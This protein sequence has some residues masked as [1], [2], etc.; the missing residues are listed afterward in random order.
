M[1]LP[2]FSLYIKAANFFPVYAPGVVNWIRK[3]A[4]G[5]TMQFSDADKKMIVEGL[6]KLLKDIEK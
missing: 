3:S 5:S 1:N 6:R 2:A 4:P